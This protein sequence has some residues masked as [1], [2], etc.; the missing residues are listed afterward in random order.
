[1]T[2]SRAVSGRAGR[3][4]ALP[5]E[6]PNS[7]EDPRDESVG[8]LVGRLVE[9][10]KA[11]AKAEVALYKAVAKRR[12][13]RAKS[14][15]MLVG[16]GVTLL[17]CGLTALVITLIIG[18]GYLI[19]NHYFWGGLITFVLLTIVG[20]LLAK[21]GAG[22]LAALGGDEEERRALGVTEPAS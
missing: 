15:A 12:V 19:G 5:P 18:I 6:L 10:G 21:A 2:V 4:V 7:I 9:D 17:M 13:G 8:A 11:Y 16:I 3:A 1:M 14:G 22:G 20:G